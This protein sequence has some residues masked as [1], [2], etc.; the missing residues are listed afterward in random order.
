MLRFAAHVTKQETINKLPV[1]WYGLH[2]LKLHV[3]CD[4]CL[5]NITVCT[6][7]RILLSFCGRILIYL[8]EFLIFKVCITSISDSEIWVTGAAYFEAA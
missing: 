6:K 8:R 5:H 1:I 4:I 2:E 7:L 3:P